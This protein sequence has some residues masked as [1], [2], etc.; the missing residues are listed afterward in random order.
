MNNWKICKK[1]ARFPLSTLEAAQRKQKVCFNC[2]LL[3]L[4]EAYTNCWKKSQTKIV[5]GEWINY[6]FICIIPTLVEMST[7]RIRGQ[8]WRKKHHVPKENGNSGIRWEWTA[9]Y[10]ILDLCVALET[11]ILFIHFGRNI[12][13]MWCSIRVIL[14]FIEA[15]G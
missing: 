3:D 9:F 11:P 14:F 1:R 5:L 12:V 13:C 8:K 6:I 7:P 2:T 15:M 4:A 10:G